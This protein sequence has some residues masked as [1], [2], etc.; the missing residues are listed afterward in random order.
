MN[1]F[2]RDKQWSDKFMRTIKQVLGLCL[3]TEGDFEEDAKENTDLRVLTLKSVR[4]GCRVRKYHFYEKY[5]DEFTIRYS[6]PS[7]VKTEID[8]IMEGWGDLFFYGFSNQDE[9]SLIRWTLADLNVF[10]KWYTPDKAKPHYVPESKCELIA[11]RWDELPSG[12]VVRDYDKTAADL[13][14]MTA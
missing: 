1:G 12:F 4:I 5:P 14:R 11:F 8:K 6:R 13:A 3:L 9:T 2:E 10:R 7:G